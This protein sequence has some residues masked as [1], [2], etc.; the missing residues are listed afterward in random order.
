MNYKF[1]YRLLPLLFLIFSMSLWS[2]DEI[3]TSDVETTISSFLFQTVKDSKT[4]L[5]WQKCSLGQDKD[6]CSGDAG[7]FTWLTAIAHCKKLNDQSATTGISN[8]RLPNI[9]ELKKI[10]DRSKQNPS[11]DIIKFP[12]ISMV[13]GYWTSTTHLEDSQFAWIVAFLDGSFGRSVKSSNTYGSYQH[14]RCVA[15]P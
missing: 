15:G 4:G 2:Q 11:A 14:I 5:I 7:I 8:W 9:N 3:P 12:N 13:R 10:V 6:I 1:Y